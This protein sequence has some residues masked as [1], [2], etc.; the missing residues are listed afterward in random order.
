MYHSDSNVLVATLALDDNMSAFKCLLII[1]FLLQCTWHV[2]ITHLCTEK[3]TFVLSFSDMRDII[4]PP[5]SFKGK[6]ELARLSLI[7][8]H[9]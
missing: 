2:S 5:A 8:I 7:N 4:W 6:L 9:V 3:P 1:V